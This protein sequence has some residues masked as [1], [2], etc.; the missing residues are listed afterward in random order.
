MSTLEGLPFLAL[1][2][3]VR[4]R[5]ALL[6]R[7]V[8]DPAFVVG[9]LPY[10]VVKLCASIPNLEQGDRRWRRRCHRRGQPALRHLFASLVAL[11]HHRMRMVTAPDPADPQW[12]DFPGGLV[13]GAEPT[14]DLLAL[15]LAGDRA[16]VTRWRQRRAADS[17]PAHTPASRS[18]AL[19]CTVPARPRRRRG[20]GAR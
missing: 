12:D 1:A 18:P 8:H 20:G 17:R 5:E 10:E 7:L 15:A 6:L 4:D 16:A 2:I 9:G 19:A 14:P 13:I 11:A 3:D